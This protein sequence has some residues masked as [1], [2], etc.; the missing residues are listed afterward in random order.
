MAK[1]P[2]RVW[3]EVGKRSVKVRPQSLKGAERE[4]VWRRVASL[5]PRL[6]AELQAKTDREIPV[7]RL[8]AE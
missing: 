4:E 2:D 1:Q 6:T 8:T 7:V 3:I 5:A